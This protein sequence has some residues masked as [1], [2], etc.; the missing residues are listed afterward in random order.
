M[1]C[2]VLHRRY[3]VTW[4][5]NR[6]STRG[7][8]RLLGIQSKSRHI[9]GG[10]KQKAK[11]T[12]D[13]EIS[14]RIVSIAVGAQSNLSDMLPALREVYW[15]V[16]FPLSLPPADHNRNPLIRHR[17]PWNT[18]IHASNVRERSYCACL[19]VMC[20]R[21]TRKQSGWDFSLHVFQQDQV[22]KSQEM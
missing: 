15:T 14:S 7:W 11:P 4:M 8:M 20:A 5:R 3:P 19:H 10:K 21:F 12:M 13:R 22:S 18:Y 2:I 9:R 1:L 16:E 17:Y 6:L